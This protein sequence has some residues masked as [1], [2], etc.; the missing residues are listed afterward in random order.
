MDNCIVFAAI[1]DDFSFAS[2]KLAAHHLKMQSMSDCQLQV[3]SAKNFDIISKQ[4]T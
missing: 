1:G 2:I 4:K 3:Y